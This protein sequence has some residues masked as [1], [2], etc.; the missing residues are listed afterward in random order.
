MRNIPAHAGKTDAKRHPH[1]SRPEH[2]RSR[3]ENVCQHTDEVLHEEHPRSRG[4]NARFMTRGFAQSGTSPLTRG[5]R[6]R[7][8]VPRRPHR[9]IPAH[10]GKTGLQREAYPRAAEHPRSRGENEPIEFTAHTNPGTSPLTR[11]KLWWSRVRIRVF[12]N[13]PAHAGKTPGHAPPHPARPEHPR[14]RGENSVAVAR[15]KF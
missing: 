14:S 12:G 7:P 8:Q 15:G 9:N 13:I 6:Y 5:K 10:A 3:G 2:P 1:Q 4:E 11:G